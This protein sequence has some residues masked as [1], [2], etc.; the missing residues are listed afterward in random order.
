MKKGEVVGYINLESLK[1]IPK[2]EPK[3]DWYLFVV[4]SMSEA[5]LAEAIGETAYYPQR[6]VWSKKRGRLKFG[7]ERRFKKFYPMIPGYI[8]YNGEPD[9]RAISWMWSDRRVLGLRAVDG[10]LST[11]PNVDIHRM[12]LAEMAGYE[13][14]VEVFSVIVG[15]AIEIF[16]GPYAGKMGVVRDIEFGKVSLEMLTNGQV[17]KFS[18][19]H[20]GKISFKP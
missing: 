18:V 14:V 9:D 19:S 13:A 12:R 16:S 11:V 3:R 7:E 10:R 20:L 4:R 17:A 1:P 6:F 5:K 8:F 15:E 2:A